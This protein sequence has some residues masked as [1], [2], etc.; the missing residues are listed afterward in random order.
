LTGWVLV[1]DK[2]LPRYW[3][4]V[5]AALHGAA[6]QGSTISAHLSV[7]ESFYRSVKLQL[8]EACLDRLVADLCFAKLER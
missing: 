8:N 1:D 3:T 5:W 2:D 4:T 6:L 7:I